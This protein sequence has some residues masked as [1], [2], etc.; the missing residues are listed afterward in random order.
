VHGVR[1]GSGLPLESGER[2]KDN[3]TAAGSRPRDALRRV[4]RVRW[5]FWAAGAAVTAVVLFLCALR[6]AR[7]LGADS[8]GAS[9]ALQA[10]AMLHGNLLLH[11][12][13]L[14]DASFYTTELPEYMLVELV[15]GLRPDV[16]HVCAALTYTLL[17]LLAAFVAKGRAPGRVGLARAAIAVGIMLLPPLS[18][19]SS[20]GSAA[21]DLLSVPDHTGSAV[22]VLAVLAL[23]DWGGRRWYVPLL[24]GLALAWAVVG[25][26]LLLL[27]GVVPVLVVCLARAGNRL[28][29]LR[30]PL[31]HVWYELSLAAAA[32]G[33]AGAA[34]AAVHLIRASG[35]YVLAGGVAQ[36]VPSAA[37]LPG[38]L[39]GTGQGILRLFSA[40]FFGERF[41]PGLAVTAIHLIAVALVAAG[42]W[43][44]VRRY[45]WSADLAAAI[46]ATAII[47]NVLAY[48]VIFQASFIYN[49]EVA[50]VFSLG[51]A[52]AGRVLAGPLL[53]NRLEPLLGFWLA[54]CAC[55][56]APTIPLATPTPAETDLGAWLEAR[57]LHDGIAGYSLAN[58]TALET[59]GRVR[60]RA[61][62]DMQCSGLTPL[63][64][65]TDT[66][67]L[68]SR[69]YDVNFLVTAS[70]TVTEGEGISEFGKPARV[71]RFEVYTIL[72]WHKNLLPQL[73]R[74]GLPAL[75]RALD[76]GWAQ[77]IDV[78]DPRCRIMRS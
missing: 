38:N 33:G 75:A 54:C 72:V 66:A 43:L 28:L 10:W 39:A 30:D 5:A 74:K 69:A 29:R 7:T 73:D 40:D 17:V 36:F 76:G 9:N 56:L 68:N 48:L 6:E 26:P 50:P 14:G 64:W 51:A 22:P 41:G 55:T 60:M 37:L 12:W 71:Y 42:L 27:I 65:E 2:G 59:G 53:R 25:D 46:L 4:T 52:L 31:P 47:A 49:H 24:T 77:L 62:M 20:F 3:E 19:E 1:G 11:G 67:L 18:N 57:H 61:V 34:S 21:I 8:D 23:L 45:F 15:R 63:A 78:S 13:H 16:V 58:K 32:V 35:G 70:Q 44:A